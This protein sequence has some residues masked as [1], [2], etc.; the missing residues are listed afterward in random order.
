VQATRET[1]NLLNLLDGF[2]KILH[3][4]TRSS[5]NWTFE[6]SFRH[7]NGGW[8]YDF[9]TDQRIQELLERFP[10]YKAIVETNHSS[11]VQFSDIGRLLSIQSEGGVYADSDVR[12]EIPVQEWLPVYSYDHVK[13]VGMV[14]GIEFPRPDDYHKNLF[15]ISNFCMASKPRNPILGHVLDAIMKNL[16]EKPDQH[17]QILIR[18]GPVALTT[19]VLEVF[20]QSG[21]AQPDVQ[22]AFNDGRGKLFEVMGNKVVILPYRAFGYSSFHGPDVIKGD[23]HDRLV[24][25]EHLQRWL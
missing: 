19:A 3:V 23:G 6:N 25:H 24:V 12:F 16:Q 21:V 15:Q 14:L 20:N 22:Q 5:S 8:K 13:N 18:T 4:G 2:P 1:T 7:S 10:R 9:L 17:D 11:G